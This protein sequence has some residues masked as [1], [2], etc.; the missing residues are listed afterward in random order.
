MHNKLESMLFNNFK[1]FILCLISS[2]IL[3]G[4]G[5]TSVKESDYIDTAANINPEST[6]S[7]PNEQS[8]TEDRNKEILGLYH[9][10]QPSYFMKNQYGDDMVI[11]GNKIP[12]PSIDY[13][14][15]LKENNIVTL[16]QISEE[17]GTR[18]Y[19]DGKFNVNKNGSITTI[20][21]EVSDG[22]SSNPTY[23]IELNEVSNEII[24]KGNNQPEFSLYRNKSDQS[25]DA[26]VG[27]NQDSDPQIE[28]VANINGLYQYTDESV[29]MAITVNGDNWRGSTTIITGMGDDYD[30][31]EYES[32]I[33]NGSDLY[34]S[35]GYVKIG[36]INGS[37]LT[38]SIGGSSVTL[39]KQQ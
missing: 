17:D 22:K 9:G 5:D 16:Q 28:V 32:G 12:I 21:C 4:C 29:R 38:T 36:Y 11:N 1:T 35:T 27:S 13:K 33:V 14:F 39:T 6:Q 26:S 20:T 24:C 25:E 2:N 15:I 23:T 7:N 3:I 37:S 8:S 30:K 10:V 31:T 19:Y 18:A 34:E